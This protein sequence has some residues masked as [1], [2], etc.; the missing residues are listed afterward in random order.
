MKRGAA[1]TA[2]HAV[3]LALVSLTAIP[4]ALFL[5][6]MFGASALCSKILDRLEHLSGKE[7]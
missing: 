1:Y 4:A 6:L 2:A 3:C 5:C 7:A